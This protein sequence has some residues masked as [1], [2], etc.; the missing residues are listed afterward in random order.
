MR[1][2]WILALL[3][4]LAV[5]CRSNPFGKLDRK[6]AHA[7]LDDAEA[8]IAA[9]HN[10]IALQR[11][12]AVHEIEGLDPDTRAREERLIDSAARARFAE[13]AEAD[14]DDLEDIYDT[15]LPD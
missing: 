11:L 10:K 15:K 3:A 14:P 5:G 7:Q 6:D 13:L 2:V 8:D 12:E 9:G 1:P 4:V